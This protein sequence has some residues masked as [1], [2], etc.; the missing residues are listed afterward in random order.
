MLKNRWSR[1]WKAA[2]GLGAVELG[3]LAPV[4][5]LMLLGIIDFGR[6]YWQQMEVAN[7]A[8][9]GTQYT[10]SNAFEAT[11]VTNVVRSATNLSTVLVDPA[12][13]Q[14][15]GCP[16][17]T[18]VTSGYGSYP[19]CGTCPDGSAAKGY[20]IVN[21]RICYSTLFTWPGLAY[22]TPS[23]GSPPPG[24]SGCTENQIVL[25]AQSILLK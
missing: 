5:L 25:S 22:C 14:T 4:L 12:P 10:M 19:T 11:T 21:T 17:S 23:D 9:A 20:V 2:D 13:Y 16:T 6:A 18:G 3:F 7:A 15:C 8:D 24:C 1:L